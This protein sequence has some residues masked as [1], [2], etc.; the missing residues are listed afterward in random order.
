MSLKNQITI[1]L[2]I[3]SFVSQVWAFYLLDQN[4]NLKE[5]AAQQY[6]K[7]YKEYLIDFWVPAIGVVEYI[8][9]K[10]RNPKLKEKFKG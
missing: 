1:V 4:K 2:L 9:D 8:P 3:F 7:G 10:C 6:N 5:Y